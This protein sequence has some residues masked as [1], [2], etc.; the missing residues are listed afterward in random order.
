MQEI[1]RVD[2]IEGAV[3]AGLY[4]GYQYHVHFHQP[5][6]PVEMNNS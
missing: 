2:M 5:S 6:S 4:L 1:R 3:C